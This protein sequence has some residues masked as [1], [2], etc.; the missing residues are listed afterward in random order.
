[1]SPTVAAQP[2][3]SLR[4]LVLALDALLI[5]AA[6]GVALGLHALVRAHLGLVRPPPAFA[7][8][9]PI[10]VFALPWFLVLIA[11]LGL[12]RT[13]ERVW[14]PSALVV[15]LVKLHA[16]G[17]L[18]IALWAFVTGATINRSL[19]GLFLV[20]TFLLLL[21][22]RSILHRWRR[23]QHDTGVG[24]TR[25]LLVGAPG[26]E[27][28]A[29]VRARAGEELPPELVGRLDDG[30]PPGAA[31]DPA[32][33]PRLGGPGEIDR[34]LHQHAVDL[35][36]FFPPWDHPRD[37][38]A[39]LAV[40]ETAGVPAGFAIDLA[41][42]GAAPP[43]VRE[44]YGRPF[45]AF[46]IAPKPAAALAIKHGFDVVAAG[47][48][49]VVVAPLLAAIAVAIALTMGRPIFFGQ[50]R[51][52]LFGRR[53]RMLKFRSMV[54]GAEAMRD[55]LLAANEM[56][57]PVFKITGDP[58]VT[59]LGRLLRRTSLDELPQL[60]NVVAGTMSLVGPRPLPTVEQQQIRGWHRRRLS[61]K[62]G[63]TGLWQVSGRN[64]VDFEA[65][66]K[67]DLAYVDAW[68]LTLDLSILLR[69]LPAVVCSRGA[70]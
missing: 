29:F 26:P 62:P 52:G 4:R 64:D 24:R 36:L 1:M 60:F 19:V 15:D 14:R 35:V 10:V 69:T 47:L 56:D 58:R 30:G 68:S 8:Y 45:V 25:L 59:R 6:M 34:V 61:M 37:A 18:G 70:R 12:H 41:Q 40:C 3:P 22:E 42:P 50:E 11:V 31:E 33:P 44:L 27:L 20:A 23:F 13:F 28:A 9:A 38:A 48:G 17:L 63:I 46:E 16:V 49:L 39:A 57:G 32:L 5:V 21:V 53:F 66:M 65:W 7:E 55:G 54:A 43:R 67:L 51:A 2:N